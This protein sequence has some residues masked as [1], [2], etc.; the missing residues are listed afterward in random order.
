M[1]GTVLFREEGDEKW[2]ADLDLGDDHYLQF[3]GWTDPAGIAHERVGAIVWHR[4]PAAPDGWCGGGILF[5]TAPAGMVGDR[6]TVESWEPL[7][8]SPSL[9]SNGA[10][11]A[12]TCSDH[13]FIRE[14]RW[15]RA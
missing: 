14:G 10:P 8:L 15:V 11:P 13:G 7:T 1:S 12:Y 5:S 6:W 3:Y 4:L 2:Y 9:A